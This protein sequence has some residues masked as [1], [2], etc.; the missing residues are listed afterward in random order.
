MALPSIVSGNRTT[1]NDQDDHILDIERGIKFLNP[2]DNGIKFV[3]RLIQNRGSN[4]AKSY[5]HEWVETA[6]PVRRE[7]V[8]I[9]NDSDTDVTVGNAYGYQVGDLL[10]VD[11]E[12]LRVTVVAPGAVATTITVTRSYGASAAAAHSAKVMYN[13]GSAA[14][15]NATA[16]AGI[17]LDGDKLYNYV[18]TFDRAVDMSND[19]IAQLSAEMGNPFNAQLE[20]VTL[21]FWKLLAQAIFKGERI[22]DSTL[23]IHAMGGIDYFMTTNATSGGGALTLALIDAEILQIVQAG[24]DPDVIVLSPYQ[25]QKLDALDTTAVRIGKRG[26]HLGGSLNVQTWQSGVLDHTLDVVV[27]HTIPDTEVYILDTSKLELVP[28]VNNGINGRLSVE[29]ATTP[30][31]DGKKKVLRAKYTLVV[32]MQTGMSKIYALT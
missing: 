27:D 14:I 8:T 13:L 28:L 30:G 29:D 16:P 11:D 12:I 26:P 25:K 3:K 21:Y 7:T 31:Q 15:E 18:Q 32:R 4:V 19:E 5:K 2:R 24:G 9:A 10:R 20:R 17:S 1:F 6:L 22:E 23:K